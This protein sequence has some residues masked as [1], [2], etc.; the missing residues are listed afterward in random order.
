LR[1]VA[2]R[3]PRRRARALR[4]RNHAASAGTGIAAR[5][6][7][8]RLARAV[9]EDRETVRAG[10]STCRGAVRT[11]SAPHRPDVGIAERCES[12]IGPYRTDGPG[13]AERTLDERRGRV[14]GRL[15]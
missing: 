1:P 12:A 11:L 13:I 4:A 2:A 6:A 8:F 15:R 14:S 5:P 3:G 7:A 9:V 10:D